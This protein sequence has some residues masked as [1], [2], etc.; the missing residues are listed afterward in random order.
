M[1][2]F[3][4]NSPL[5]LILLTTGMAAVSSFGQVTDGNLV[6]TVYDASGRV[7]PDAGV[8]AKNTA[9]GITAETKS[10]QGGAYR[11]N[12]LQVGSYSVTVSA[13]GFA[14]TQMKDLSVELNKIAT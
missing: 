12:N 10:D 6:G 5:L 8:Q 9:T 7:V 13:A 11:F 14:S 3:R 4:Y 1:S 2:S